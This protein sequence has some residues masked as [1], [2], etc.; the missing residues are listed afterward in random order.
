[1]DSSQQDFFTHSQVDDTD[2]ETQTEDTADMSTADSAGHT[3][4]E[5]KPRPRLPAYV[6]PH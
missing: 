4:V 5:L 3:M 2:A 6:H 1:M